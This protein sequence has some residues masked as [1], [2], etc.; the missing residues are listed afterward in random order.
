MMSKYKKIFF[1][2]TLLVIA[3]ETGV[4]FSPFKE[5]S[6]E[7]YAQQAIDACQNEGW[8]P[9]CYDLEIPKIADKY[10]LSLEDSFEVTRIVQ[11]KD[12]S[13]QYCHVLGHELSA[14]EVRKNPDNWK[15]VVAR[16]PS[17]MC[18]NGCLHGGFQ[19]K[20]RAEYLPPEQIP[21]IKKDLVD[22]CEAR[23]NWNPTG[24][25]QA[26]CYHALGHLTMYITN[27][28]IPAA[29]EVCEETTLKPDGR[30][31]RQLCYDGV[32]M[33]MFQPLEPEDF[34]LIEGRQPTREEVPSFCADYDGR[35]RA[36]CLSES[37]PLFQKDLMDPKYVP[38][39][40]SM[41]ESQYRPRCYNAVFYVMT[42]RIGFDVEKLSSYCSE[43]PADV[44]G[45][46]FANAA[47]R[48]IETDY[49]NVEKSVTLCEKA[50]EFGAEEPCFRELLQYST[51]NFHPGSEA[52]FKLCNSLPD[53][54][55]EQC[56]KQSNN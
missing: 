53:N 7:A 14:R 10:E 54:W 31:F 8:R 29:I 42:T 5:F 6:F 37:W 27:A 33:Q 4:L 20:F 45:T 41:T 17:G 9:G 52:F 56:L 38:D 15:E 32:F 12:S 1:T 16:C 36:S 26:S 28:D 19:E 24:L 2:A 50:A 13:Y 34:A 30:D 46:C 40:C 44:R 51:F 48:M 11:D 18:S 55:R 23:D 21:S 3:V 25:E 22:L 43:L 49:R 47:S 35:K 39:F